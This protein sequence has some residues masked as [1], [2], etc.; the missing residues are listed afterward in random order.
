MSENNVQARSR[1]LL[2]DDE[3]NILSALR[4]VF[5]SEPYD[6]EVF[7]DAASALACA[8]DMDFA[9]A[10][11]DYRMPEV[12]GV[13]F[14]TIFRSL[15]PDAM[16]LILSGFTDL[17]ALLGAINDA[18]IYRFITKPWQ[19]YELRTTVAQALAH[20]AAL[21]DRKSVV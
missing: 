4:R 5:A 8:K 13:S 16:R 1:I 9:L 18:H 21:L 6:L 17:E 3:P 12:D 14:L 2:L 19:D 15:R 7:T 11:S 10:I 20:R